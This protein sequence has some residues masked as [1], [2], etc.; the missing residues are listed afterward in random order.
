MSKRD[1]YANGLT[2]SAVLRLIAERG[3]VS[4]SAIADKLGLSRSTVTRVVQS[5]LE[6]GFV[7]EGEAVGSHV[8]RKRILLELNPGHI[9]F[10]G[11]DLA[12]QCMRGALADLRGAIIHRVQ[13]EP[14]KIGDGR[15]NLKMLD[16][17]IET[18]LQYARSEVV[19]ISAMGIGVPASG[20][21]IPHFTP[22]WAERL[23]WVDPQL[24]RRIRDRY[25]LKTCIEN[26]GD[27]GA[28]SEQ[29]LGAGKGADDL[30]YLSVG[31]GIGGGVIIG[32]RLHRGF[33][34]VA[35]TPGSMIPDPACLGRDYATTFGCLESLASE[36][37]IVRKASDAMAAGESSTLVSIVAE[38]GEVIDLPAVLNAA[39]G[40]DNLASRLVDYLADYLAIVVVNVASLIDPEVI[41]IG[42]YL[43]A[44]G[45]GLLRRIHNRAESA[46][47]AMPDLRLS[48]LGEDAVLLGAIALAQQGEFAG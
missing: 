19:D 31:Q 28:I 47:R 34:H 23:G 17:L 21:D 4:R 44:A 14:I 29:W 25:G 3:A 26:D 22:I 39:E 9:S 12:G 32:G 35:G 33:H 16:D 42:G 46:V 18:L 5:L 45:E 41:V 30:V 20:L 1:L 24:E 38:T 2:R 48:T 10:I 8:G 27:L 15:S 6:E 11:L 7:R 13:S 40:G 37:V 43:G 36:S